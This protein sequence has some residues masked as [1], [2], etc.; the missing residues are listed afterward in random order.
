MESKTLFAHLRRLVKVNV[1]SN[2]DGKSLSAAPFSCRDE[3]LVQ[4]SFKGDSLQHANMIITNR[5]IYQRIGDVSLLPCCQMI[6][7]IWTNRVDSGLCKKA[8]HVA[9]PWCT[10]DIQSRKLGW[11]LK[12]RTHRDHCSL[13]QEWSLEQ[14]VWAGLA[15]FSQWRLYFLKDF[16]LLLL[17]FQGGKGLGAC[18][19]I[20]M[21][22][23]KICHQ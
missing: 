1:A 8:F 9:V 12:S 7:Y 17:P 11:N 20:W 19:M 4:Y 13:W 15:S 10:R 22:S 18:T 21:L 14:Y 6:W 2:V 16:P 5:H 23:I 3:T